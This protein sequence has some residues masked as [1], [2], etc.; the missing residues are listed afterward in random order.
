MNHTL[1]EGLKDPV[2]GMDVTVESEH[3]FSFQNKPY[4]FCSPH[5]LDKFKADPKSYLDGNKQD[6]KES[7]A[8][9]GYK[10]ETM[11]TC[12]MHPEIRQKGQ[13]SCHKCGM[14]LEPET[15]VMPT[16]STQYTCPMHPEIIQDEPGSCPKCGMALEPMTVSVDEEN[17]E[18]DDMLKR[19]RY[20]LI[21]AFL[22]FVLAMI[23]DLAPQW[24]PSGLSM[25][26]VQWIEFIL[27]TPVVIWGGWPFF[28]RGWQSVK[29]WNLNMF[30]LIAMG[31]GVAWVYSVVA[32]LF[33][34]IFPPEMRHEGGTVAVY[35]EA[36]AV[37]TVLVL[38][39]QVLELKARSSTNAAIKAL[40]ELA[41]KTVRR[42]DAN[43]NEE[44][45]P[46]EHVQT[47]DILRVRPG[48]KIPI[49]G[50]VTEGQSSVDESMITGEP[51][52]VPKKLEIL[53]L[54]QP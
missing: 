14:A 5:C 25:K 10:A 54:V 26:T 46:L 2:C 9:D 39:G 33:P 23:A 1:L 37:I 43:G 41:P 16:T 36:A 40:L 18:L 31:V 4:Y 3:S 50:R 44:D 52:P 49:D 53:S 22:V 42:I 47:G 51:I 8:E 24:L 30:T 17:H 13:G 45:I 34:S 32:M 12:P 28:V 35:F 29:T 21:P 20:S 48:E 7:D 15:F 19:F 11:Y 27:A 38:L 6:K